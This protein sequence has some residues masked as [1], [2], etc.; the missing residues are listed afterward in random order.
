MCVCIRPGHA[1][2]DRLA[3]RKRS[4]QIAT[5]LV[6]ASTALFA[7]APTAVSN[8]CNSACSQLHATP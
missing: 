7:F 8:D 1:K 4:T 5:A 3:L 2:A 6:V